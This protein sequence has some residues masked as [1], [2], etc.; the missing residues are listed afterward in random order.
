[1]MKAYSTLFDD[2]MALMKEIPDD[3][4]WYWRNSI[5]DDMMMTF[6]SI[7]WR[8]FSYLILVMKFWKN[9]TMKLMI[10][11]LCLEDTVDDD[12]MKRN[13]VLW[14]IFWNEEMT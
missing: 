6:V 1:M 2:L 12:T 4:F 7:Q 13:V 3:V 9:S 5:I 14:K 10:L 11:L 8:A